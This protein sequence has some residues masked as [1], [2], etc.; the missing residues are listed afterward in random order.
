M[1]PT[2]QQEFLQVQMMESSPVSLQHPLRSLPSM[3]E[4]PTGSACVHRTHAKSGEQGLLMAPSALKL[5]PAE[6]M[7]SWFT[8]GNPGNWKQQLGFVLAAS[9]RGDCCVT[10]CTTLELP[11]V[12]RALPYRVQPRKV[13]LSLTG[14]L[15]HRL[16]SQIHACPL[17]H[18]TRCEGVASG[19]SDP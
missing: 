2:I 3:S 18:P 4:R 8:A 19:L 15:Q 6:G 5:L 12:L 17:L 14:R 13:A 9:A 7:G 11:R 1:R 10:A 16:A